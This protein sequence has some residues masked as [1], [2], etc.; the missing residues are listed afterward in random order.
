ML[1]ARQVRCYHSADCQIIMGHANEA[2]PGIERATP[3][4][5][6]GSHDERMVL[7][8]N[9]TLCEPVGAVISLLNYKYLEIITD[10]ISLTEPC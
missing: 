4:G 6:T 8:L 7:V 3:V 1:P 5:Q 9:Y 2:V 10:L